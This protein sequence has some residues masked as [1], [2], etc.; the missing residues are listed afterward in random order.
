MAEEEKNGNCLNGWKWLE[1]TGNGLKSLKMAG[2]GNYS[3]DAINNGDGKELFRITV[4]YCVLFIYIKN[5][6]WRWTGLW[7][8]M[9]CV[10]DA[11]IL[12]T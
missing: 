1:M 2:S 9:E 12:S 3:D 8:G 7:A 4:F 6:F 5:Q 11:Q 10:T